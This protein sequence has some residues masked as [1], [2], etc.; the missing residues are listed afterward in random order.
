MNDSLAISFLT[1]LSSLSSSW[2]SLTYGRS[3]RRFTRASLTSG[4]L[5]L[6]VVPPPVPRLT[7]FAGET[8]SATRMDGGKG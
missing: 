7:T 5:F 3:F 8:G 1:L 6:P 2:S 4:R